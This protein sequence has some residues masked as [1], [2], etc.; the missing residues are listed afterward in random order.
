MVSESK[1]IIVFPYVK[2]VSET[3]TAAFDNSDYIA[4]YRCLNKLNRYIKTH[5]DK[6]NS[7][8]QNNVI[9]R[10]C[11]KDCD[12]TYIG[13]TKRQLCTRV[14]EH[15]NNI[16]LDPSKH[17]VVTEHIIKENHMFD[18]DNTQIMDI[19]KNFHKRLISETIHIKEQSNS[20]NLNKDT[21]LLDGSY[22]DIFKNTF[23]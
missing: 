22:F 21:E 23:C 3:I 18:W 16:R 9:Y 7:N 11:C 19:E 15:K 20:I 17:S 1:K 10:I 2:N 12:A 5:K 6:N 13:Q 8:N 14:K 4:G